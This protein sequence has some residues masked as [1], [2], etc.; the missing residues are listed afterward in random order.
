MSKSFL[1]IFFFVLS[2]VASWAEFVPDEAT[3]IRIAV[4]AWE[5]TYGEDKVA[6]QKPFS[7][8]QV[9]K[10]WQVQPSSRKRFPGGKLYA[11]VVKID[12]TVRTLNRI[13]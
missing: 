10:V 2:A 11:E 13:E 9:G 7:A 1:S 5:A 12:G 3:A 4:A 6:E 8:V